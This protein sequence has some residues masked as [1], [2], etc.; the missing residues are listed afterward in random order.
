MQ[1]KRGITCYR[2]NQG[3]VGASIKYFEIEQKPTPITQLQRAAITDICNVYKHHL[4][5]YAAAL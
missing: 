4:P 3:W 5:R 1:F 2:G